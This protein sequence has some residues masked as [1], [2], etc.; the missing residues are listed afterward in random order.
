MAY[1]KPTSLQ[2]LA[3]DELLKICKA[4]SLKH[5]ISVKNSIDIL[6]RTYPDQ[7]KFI[8]HDRYTFYNIIHNKKISIPLYYD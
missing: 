4:F 2:N 1:Y 5:K 8:L 6:F 3:T 7:I